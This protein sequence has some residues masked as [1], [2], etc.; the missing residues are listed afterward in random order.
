[1]LY[2]V[3]DSCDREREMERDTYMLTSM[4]QASGGR[5]RDGMDH[6]EKHPFCIAHSTV[7]TSSNF[8]FFFLT[9]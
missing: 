9:D 4:L 7:V 5:G 1:M 6:R 2:S 8:T 3:P